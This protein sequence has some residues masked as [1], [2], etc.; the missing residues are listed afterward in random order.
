M[1]SHQLQEQT[2]LLEN[3]N[4]KG[5]S[6]ET[7][8]GRTAHNMSSS[9]L[10]KKSDRTLVSKV[11]C[12]LLRNLLVNFQ[13]VILGTKLS[14]LFPAIPAAIFS[15]CYGFGRPLVFVL[16]L[17][18]LT[19]LAERVS[20][21]T[22]QVAYYTGPTVGGLLNATCGNVTELVIAILALSSNKIAVVKYSLLGSIL[23]NLLLV[24]GTSLFCGG[25]ANLRAEQ[26]Y[27]RRQADVN[28]LMLL[29]GL[30]CH[31][32]PMLFRYGAAS[33]AL[34]ADP[35]L[36][37]SRASSIVMLIAYFAY[38]VF[39]LWTHREL[40][41]AEEEVGDGNNASEEQAVIGFWSGFAWLVGMTVFIALLSEYVVDTIE[42]AS[43]SWGLSVSFL[44]IILLPIVG[45]AAE[46]AGAVIFAF[47]NK[48]DISLG[49]ALGS[50]T[51]ISMF[52]VPLCVTVAWIM[53]VKMDLNFNLLETG[54][55]A[56][57]IIATSFTLQDGSS[58]YMKGLILLLCYIVIGACFF[59]QR[60]PFD[61]ANVTNITVK[62]ATDAVLSA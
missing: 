30:L 57:A 19:P 50:A 45:N 54:S 15:Q 46:H 22:E 27:D 37:L 47:K 33:P 43:D 39:Q 29:L 34:T 26:K 51:Q 38:L 35:S 16:S 36:Y 6:K 52:V 28:S 2:W 32:L 7:K 21:I 25:I 42:D 11:R 20:F 8:H 13:E 10:R 40:F 17:V 3:G 49:V 4:I 56:L 9:S 53:G 61:Q 31:L 24:L 60:T 62:S 1:G 14:I 18:G 41:E 23:S 55:L 48:L 44:S 12:A 58:H 59:V 5:L